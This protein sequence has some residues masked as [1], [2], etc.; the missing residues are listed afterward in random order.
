M[1]KSIVP[2]APNRA[3]HTAR[4][5]LFAG[6]MISAASM[7]LAD[8]RRCDLSNQVPI[9]PECARINR[10]ITV[11]MPVEPNQE[12]VKTLPGA[13]FAQTGFSISIEDET[14]AGA[15]APK[16]P[17]RGQDRALSRAAVDVTYDGLQ[18]QPRLNVA[19]DDLRTS[20]AGGAPVTFRASSNYPAWI[21][22][23]EVRISEV[24]KGGTDAVTALP[25]QPNGSVLWT[26][27]TTGSGDYTY[28]VRVYDAKGRYN[29]TAPLPLS[30]SDGRFATHALTSA[31]IIAAGEGDDR[32]AIAHIPISG[33]SITA[34]GTSV[35]AGTTV[36]VMGE[37]VNVDGTG[38]FVIQR[39]LPTGG[40]VVDVSVERGG[41]VLDRVAR[42]IDIPASDWFYVAIAD[43]TV[44]RH[45]Q[46]AD[47]ADKGG[48]T[49]GR[50]AFY[51]KGKVKGQYLITSSLDTGEGDLSEMFDR[52]DQKDPR[53][54]LR[55]LDPDDYYPV[56]GDD[57][58]AFDDTPTSGRFYLRVER[59][60]SYAVWGD[61]KA[62][63]GGTS[64]LRNDRTLYG[65][66]LHYETS[67]VTASG[68]ARGTAD[69][70][71]ATPETL[72]QRDVLTG[73]GGSA[74]LLSRQD[75]NGGSE[76]V[77]VEVVDP[78]T[79]RVISRRQL[80]AGQ[81][82][83]LDYIQGVVLLAAPLSS[84]AGTG[85]VISNGAS[86]GNQ[87]RLIA[88]YE[89]TPAL[90]SLAGAAIGG[91][92]SFWI[93]DALRVGVTALRETTGVADQRMEGADLEY[94]IGAASKITAEVATSEGPGF[95][96]T[97]SSDGGLSFGSGGTSGALGTRALAYKLAADFDLADLGFTGAG[98]FGFYAERKDAGFSTLSEDIS[99]D[100][101]LYGIYGRI[102]A[103]A[104][105]TLAFTAER[106][107]RTGLEKKAELALELGY[108]LNATWRVDAG[109]TFTDRFKVST[110][111]E[112]GTRTDLGARLT[113]APSTDTS[114]YVFGQGTL[115]KTGGLPNNNRIG[116]GG[117]ARLSENLTFGGEVSQGDGGAG[118]KALLS[119]APSADTEVHLGYTLDPTRTGAGYSLVG[120]DSGTV[121]FGGRHKAS[122]TITTYGE[123]K[124]DLFGQR[125]SFTEAYG[126]TYTPD[127]RWTVSG[128]VETG[129][130]TDVANGDFDRNAV[131]LG[132][133]YSDADAWKWRARLE[134]RDENGAGLPQD[135][136]T[137]GLT[138]GFEYKVSDD[139]RALGNIDALISNSDQTAF[140]D[141]EYVEA[142]LGYA[143]RPV[144]N[145]RTNALAKLSYLRDL[146]GAD[147]VSADGSA[148]GPSQK[149]LMFSIDVNQ[150]I[151][152]QLTIGGK[153]GFRQSQ[154]AARGTLNF[155]DS[156]AHLAILRADWHVVHLW[157]VLV[158]GRVLF[159]EQSNTTEQGALAAVY[160]QLG[161]NAKIGLGYE[162]GHVSDDLSAIDYKSQGVFL[163]LIA[164]F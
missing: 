101:S 94:R 74:Y 72:P 160:R 120:Q 56:Y 151:G 24:K 153:Y 22:R 21:A 57:S 116:V 96:R 93:N 106:F 41:R 2:T 157:D 13:G 70:Y 126:V 158:E 35:G 112:T 46:A 118:A 163:N 47:P 64:L 149:S 108:K 19:T 83:T 3:H 33:G 63:I 142:S 1:T 147:Q 52:L 114:A 73:T 9:P 39:I 65:A 71:A 91:R 145:D 128:A 67:D 66:K 164:S 51:V 95:G 27:P 133:A 105:T 77:A 18:V 121:V 37:P 49:D 119:Y 139:W 17:D 161:N 85:G 61:F 81:D 79:G 32:T 53:N 100:Q 10:D 113:W 62:G 102:E 69:V 122:E 86:G 40:H 115:A 38:D 98:G 97:L 68:D 31:N 125:R 25:V 110:P 48:Y 42:D 26:M 54:V 92:A 141:G 104:R 12:E 45:L 148:N 55:R 50:A 43:I 103:N 11:V 131:S 44:G 123:N 60:K 84:S 162:W 124:A 136:T 8:T 135:R 129:Q 6:L 144:A 111:V 88:Q 15:P 154:V 82:Y 127:A 59:D 134:Y 138:G 58:T 137:Y 14:I 155:A 130:V 78:V 146:P 90:G 30:Q 150:D 29:E 107:Q 36:R 132:V 156:T 20:Y 7:A 28:V 152:R 4:L 109:L 89:Y 143:Y 75:I 16:N 34:S 87:V 80:V 5:T 159:T 99:A 117:T 23:A 76:T 140:R